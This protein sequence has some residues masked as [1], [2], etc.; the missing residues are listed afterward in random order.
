MSDLKKAIATPP[1]QPTQ[2]VSLSPEE[3][4][5]R[6]L[7]ELKNTPPSPYHMWH[8]VNG[9]WVEDLEHAK[10]IRMEEFRAMRKP[11]FEEIGIEHLKAYD[12]NEV[13]RVN[14]IKAK[15]Q[16]MRDIPQSETWDGLTTIQEIADYTPVI[17]TED[18]TNL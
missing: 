15:R 14:V 16:A 8:D 4:T 18:L 2:H 10:G 12:N 1:G 17:L 6:E 3:V 13:D 9:V 7:E 11:R 5:A